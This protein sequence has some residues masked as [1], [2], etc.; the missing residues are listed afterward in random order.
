LK[1]YQ[2]VIFPKLL[3]FF[4]QKITVFNIKM[5]LSYS[6]P[7]K[8][9]LSKSQF[10]LLSKFENQSTNIYRFQISNQIFN[11]TDEET[12]LLSPKAFLQISESK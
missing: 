7:E 2:K 8:V 5:L 10:H 11:L 3:S 1:N 4:R 6:Y 9:L 12:F